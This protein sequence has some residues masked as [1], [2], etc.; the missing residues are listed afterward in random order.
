VAFVLDQRATVER[1]VRRVTR[2]RLDE[3]IS[4][5]SDLDEST[6]EEIEHAIHGVRKRCKEVRAVARLVRSALGDDFDRF[7]DD[8]RG[9]ADALAPIRDAHALLGTFDDLRATQTITDDGELAVVRAAQAATAEDATRGVIGSDPR[10]AEARALLVSSR[11]QVKHWKIP[12]GF[13]TLGA[14]IEDTYRRGA[15]ALRRARSRPTDERVHEWRKSVKHLWYQVRLIERSAP[16][17]LDALVTA[18]DDLAE[19]LGDDHDLAVLVDRLVADPKAFGGKKAAKRARRLARLQQADLRRRAFRLGAT[20][21]AETPRAFTARMGAYWART[22]DLG[23]ELATGGIAEL[24]HDEK[25]LA[26][27]GERQDPTH[28]L[29][30]ERKF[31]VAQLPQLPEHGVA[32]R[33]GYLAI[34]GTVS[35]RVRDAAD[36]GATLTLK[37]GRGAVRTELE[38]PLTAEQFAA[39]WEQTRGRR[40][41]KT[42]YRMH[43]GEHVIELDVFDDD[44]GGLVVAEVEFESDAALAAFRPPAWFGTEV[45]DDETYTNASLAANAPLGTPSRR[46]DDRGSP[47][48]GPPPAPMTP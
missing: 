8:V 13:D 38:W 47:H 41:S 12:D 48:V 32:L 21:Y 19:A 20:V 31:L 2:E 34:D 30:R 44:L 17:V 25:R 3:A 18:L 10:I 11:K 40:I 26:H 45:T 27:G 5:L 37:A 42:R 39:A 22:A 33:Q 23:P 43:S 16:S 35:V 4:M 9:A 6:A 1:E 46:S 29:E 36:E 15:R 7:N 24:A 28:L 14:G